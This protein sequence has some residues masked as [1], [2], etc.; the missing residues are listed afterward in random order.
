MIHS[1]TF[2]KDEINKCWKFEDKLV[3]YF[4]DN[5]IQLI[6][7]SRAFRNRNIRLLL[8]KNN[9]EF[10]IDK[11]NKLFLYIKGYEFEINSK[12]TIQESVTRQLTS[13]TKFVDKLGKR[14]HSISIVSNDDSGPE[15]TKKIP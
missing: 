2:I 13:N 12:L 5:K 3:I 4:N 11:D 9:V 10:A 15:R 14:V 6:T 1:S 7:D 8:N